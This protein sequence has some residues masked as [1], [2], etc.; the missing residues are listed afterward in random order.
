MTIRAPTRRFA[1]YLSVE[2]VISRGISDHVA[3][4]GRFALAAPFRE[5]G[6][7]IPAAVGPETERE[8]FELTDRAITALGIESA[9]IHTEIKLSPDGPKLIEVDGRLGGRPPF[10]LRS[11]SDVNLW[12]AVCKVALGAPVAGRGVTHPDC[13][14]FWRMIQPPMNAHRVRQVAGL[15]ELAEAPFVD[16][17]RLSRAPG[18]AVDWQDGT[19]GKV[20]TVC[21]R[22]R[23]LAELASAI[24]QIDHT[25]SIDYEF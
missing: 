3:V 20:L 4:C 6:N 12:R 7:F 9:V 22:V 16:S 8:L 21:G 25:V 23:D 11:I 10:V 17:V 14:A 15:G 18:D 19:D 1:S 24:D 13:V 5:T 2:S